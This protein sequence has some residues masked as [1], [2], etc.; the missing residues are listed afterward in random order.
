M[1]SPPSPPESVTT[2]PRPL[3]AVLV[4]AILAALTIAVYWPALDNDFVNYDDPL[5]VTENAHL[6]QAAAPGITPRAVAWAFTAIEGGNWH[7]LTWLSLMLDARW[8]PGTS[9][10]PQAFHLTNVLLHAAN[11]GLLFWVLFRLTARLWPSAFAAAFFALHPL[12]VE[13]VAWVS[14]RK[15]VLSTLFWMLTLLAYGWYVRRPSIGRY[16]AVSGIFALGLLSK[17]MLVTLPCV[18]LLLD[19]WPLRRVGLGWKRLVWEKA[20][21][22]ALS[23]VICAITLYAQRATHATSDLRVI[24]L[25]TRLSNALVAY[26]TYLAKTVWPTNL[27][28]LYLHPLTGVD[29]T[30]AAGAA[31][32]LLCLSIAAWRL[33]RQAPYLLVGWLWY[34]GT[35]VPVIGLIQVG[36]QSMADRYTYVPLIGIFVAVVWSVADLARRG[37]GSMA[38]ASLAIAALAGCCLLTWLQIHVWSDAVTL[39]THALEG[40]DRNPVAHMLLG[41]ALWQRGDRYAALNRTEEAARWH[42]RAVAQYEACVTQD[43]HYAQGQYNLGLALYKAGEDL[44]AIRE[45]VKHLRL[46]LELDPQ[47]VKARD[48]LGRALARLGSPAEAEEE[49]RRVIESEP[50]NATAWDNLGR[51]L[52]RQPEPAKKQEAVRCFE[53]AERLQ[54]RVLL[55]QCALAWALEQQ[56]D[57]TGAEARYQQA[58]RLD[59]DWPHALC[60]TAWQLAT[61]PGPPA[62]RDPWLALELAAQAVR[63]TAGRDCRCLEALAAA[64]AEAAQW[65]QAVAVAQKARAAAAAQHEDR[66]AQRVDQALGHYRRKEPFRDVGT[67]S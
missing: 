42:E 40:D 57:R 63:R 4:G 47:L 45:G 36:Q 16:L 41:G 13:S 14:E 11:A 55:F 31:V 59:G 19:Y 5:Y 35:L 49:F 52:Q 15:D 39:W 66:V 18:L 6:R 2:A 56:G 1:R 51:S 22:F 28:A 34:V 12:H 24:P 29:L 65:D 8:S 7:P 53:Q 33:R 32:V 48:S 46:A 37:G 21:L 43:P 27:A 3:A 58:A 60:E 17:P 61:H 9:P 54:P 50:D 26:G 62:G 44:N 20:P 10:D 38:A 67:G 30:R 23:T 64:H 25:E